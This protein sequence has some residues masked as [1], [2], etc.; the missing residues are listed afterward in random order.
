MDSQSEAVRCQE[1]PRAA[2]VGVGIAT[3]QTR[4]HPLQPKNLN[5]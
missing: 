2:V 3:R 1:V 4:L 5:E